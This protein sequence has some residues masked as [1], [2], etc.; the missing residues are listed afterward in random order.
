MAKSVAAFLLLVF[1]A[2][3]ALALSGATPDLNDRFPYVVA[4]K[5]R[6]R[7]ICSGTVLF[8]RIVVTA[9]HCVQKKLDM[10][11]NLFAD[12]Y[13]RRS[14]LTVVAVRNGKPE[15]YA[16]ANVIASPVWRNY[17]AKP[18]A[19]ERY[20]YDLGLIITKDPIDVPTPPSLQSL[21]AD[22]RVPTHTVPDA[23]KGDVV[24]DG[25]QAW[26]DTLA[27]A[28]TR[29][30]I[31]VGFGATD[32]SALTRCGGMGIRRY[33]S[34]EIRDPVE[35]FNAAIDAHG[36]PGSPRIEASAAAVLPLAVW[37]TDF[38]VMPGDSGGALLIEGPAGKLYYLGV[39]SSHWGSYTEKA[40]K[41][42]VDKRSFAAAL[43]PSLDLISE[44]ARKLGYGP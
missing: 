18:N 30:G 11:K 1:A 23:A 39:I 2:T 12:E 13:L 24:D 41:R 3:E 14:Q 37:C 27:E 8:P 35:C 21:A 9:A 19:G 44:E 38:G 17:V 36:K 4:I 15:S 20:A 5:Y 40:T 25:T 43:Y 26:R 31:F 33:R 28:L 32:C 42:E 6:Q 34:V 10:R 29:N 7:F 16:V 22:W